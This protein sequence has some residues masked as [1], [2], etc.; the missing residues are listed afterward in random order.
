MEKFIKNLLEII[1]IIGSFFKKKKNKLIVLNENEKKLQKLDI[2]KSLNKQQIR[3]LNSVV[4][5]RNFKAG[6]VIYYTGHPNKAMYFILDGVVEF[7]DND[8]SGTPITTIETGDVVG[9]IEIFSGLERF[10][11]AVA[12]TKCTLLAI[13]KYDFRTLINDNPQIGAKILYNFNEYFAVNLRKA[14]SRYSENGKK[15]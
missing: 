13:S 6:E 1:H 15:D 10:N 5:E 14:I 8:T 7:F 11:T 12:K 3:Y 9:A 2:F 4:F